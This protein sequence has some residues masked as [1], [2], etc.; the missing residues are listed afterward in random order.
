MKSMSVADEIDWNVE[1]AE[2][3]SND[4]DTF[5]RTLRDQQSLFARQSRIS[6]F[7]Q[8]PKMINS[9][10]EDESSFQYRVY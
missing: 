7:A 1:N 10:A 6:S 2:S 3:E 8:E 5:R 4:P 9:I